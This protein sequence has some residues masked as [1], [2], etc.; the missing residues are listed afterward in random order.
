MG[1]FAQVQGVAAGWGKKPSSALEKACADLKNKGLVRKAPKGGGKN[2]IPVSRD[3]CVYLVLA[4]LAPGPTEAAS[5]AQRFASL[6]CQGTDP[7]GEDLPE[8]SLLEAFGNAVDV[9]AE[10]LSRGEIIDPEFMEQIKRWELILCYDPL[11]A[12]IISNN[13]G[14][15]RKTYYFHSGS[16]EWGTL[17]NMTMFS[18]KILL[19]LGEILADSYARLAR[20]EVSKR[21]NKSDFTK[22]GQMPESAGTLRQK[23][24]PAPSSYPARVNGSDSSVSAPEGNEDGEGSQ[25]RLVSDAHQV[26]IGKLSL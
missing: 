17:A 15:G 22:Q 26:S 19:D 21:Y 6:H 4:L 24:T 3:E 8:E 10:P 23:G 5:T 25:G 7:V 12:Y 13:K 1:V 16:L 11:V 18:G 14:D 9:V 2:A 20:E